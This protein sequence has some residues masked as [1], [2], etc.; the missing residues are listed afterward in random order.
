M[1]AVY[2]L[3]PE[4]MCDLT[5]GELWELRGQFADVARFVAR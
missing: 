5:V 1:L 3:G 2:G 4:E